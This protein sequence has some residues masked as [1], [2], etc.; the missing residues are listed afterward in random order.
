[1]IMG[2]AAWNR[3]MFLLLFLGLAGITWSPFVWA[4][5]PKGHEITAD[6]ASLDRTLL[7]ID[8]K[9]FLQ[10]NCCPPSTAAS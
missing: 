9:D 2:L 8:I 1:M 4:H 3:F 7:R 5:G 10:E 6:G